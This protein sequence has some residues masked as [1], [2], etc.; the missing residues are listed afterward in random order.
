MKT[1]ATSAA[2]A[3]APQSLEQVL[4]LLL[5]GPGA[6]AGATVWQEPETK[7]ALPVR[8]WPTCWW[9]QQSPARVGPAFGFQAS[10]FL[11][12]VA[13]RLLLKARVAVIA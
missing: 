7:P 6:G 4:T 12:P 5:A 2:A 10:L 1:T 11:L 9:H 13:D 8:F 3:A